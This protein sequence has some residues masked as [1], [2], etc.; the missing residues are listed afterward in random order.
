MPA[1][2]LQ[3]TPVHGM[4]PPHGSA[5]AFCQPCTPAHFLCPMKA[6][7][8]AAVWLRHQAYLQ[9]P[10]TVAVRSN[11]SLPQ[12]SNNECRAV[13]QQFAAAVKQRLPCGQTK[14]CR[15][16]QTNVCRAVKQQF[17]AAVKHTRTPARPPYPI[18][19]TMVH[20]VIL[21][22]SVVI[23]DFLVGV[24]VETSTRIDYKSNPSGR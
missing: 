22:E 4:P 10:K 8:S 23:D 17:A 18:L 12:R 6:A 21:G 16:G 5:L 24:R 1:V 3:V 20:K 11:D 14:V 15:S 7:R 9:P 19:A 2:K 13:K